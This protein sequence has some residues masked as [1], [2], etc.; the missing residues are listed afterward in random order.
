[1][2]CGTHNADEYHY[3]KSSGRNSLMIVDVPDSTRVHQ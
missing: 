2:F 3:Q 1:M